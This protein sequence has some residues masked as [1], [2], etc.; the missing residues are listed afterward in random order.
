[1]A[2]NS[3]GKIFKIT[4]FGESHGVAVGVIIDGCPSGLTITQ[5]EIQNVVNTRKG[6]QSKYT[7]K[8]G[9][10]DEIEILSGI[11]NNITLGTPICIVVYNKDVK[12][13]DYDA[14]KNLY[15]PS[16]ADFTWHNK[17]NHTDHRGGGRSSA[18][19]TVGRVIAGAIALK[20]LAQHNINIL[21]YIYAIGNNHINYNNFN[22]NNINNNPLYCPDETVLPQW[23]NILDNAIASGDSVG[24]VVGITVTNTPVGLGEP[25]FEKLNANLGKALFTIPAVKGV[26]FGDGFT[27]SKNFG[28]SVADELHINNGT[29]TFSSNHNGGILGGISNGQDITI[30]IA[31]KPTSSIAKTQNTVTKQNT[32]TTVAV[33]GRH[34]PC[35]AI[36]AVSVC[37]AMVAIVLVDYLL[38]SKVRNI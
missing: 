28:S 35:I 36:R 30:K 12:S 24:G 7:T 17:F 8:R 23:F 18:R 4:T 5:Q 20:I 21:S 15:R 29:A 16:H 22:P 13:K 26:E 2:F 31:I 37:K 27:L 14:L 38:I 3:F 10:P 11:Y 19:E 25:V 6:N 9:E 32:A 1:M 34:D 33:T